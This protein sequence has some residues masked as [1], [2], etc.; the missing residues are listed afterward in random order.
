VLVARLAVYS[1][2]MTACGNLEES[3]E[4]HDVFPFAD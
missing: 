2:A 4:E 1:A 3:F